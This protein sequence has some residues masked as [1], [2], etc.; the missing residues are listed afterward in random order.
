[1]FATTSETVTAFEN[2]IS[3][4]KGFLTGIELNNTNI[5]KHGDDNDKR[6]TR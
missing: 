4:L 6:K 2:F 3:D 1:M 5:P